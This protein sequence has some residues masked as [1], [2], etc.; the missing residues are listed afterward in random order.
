MAKKTKAVRAKATP[1]N[2]QPIITKGTKRLSPLIHAHCDLATKLWLER[3]AANRRETL[4]D[5]V[6]RILLETRRHKRAA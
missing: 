4:G 3:V 1:R 5:C 6:A 2:H